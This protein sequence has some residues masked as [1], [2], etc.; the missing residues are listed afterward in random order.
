MIII[1]E[2]LDRVGKDTQ[3]KLLQTKLID[4]PCHIFHYSA[5][6]NIDNKVCKKYSK[7]LYDDG[8]KII[9]KLYKNRH[10]IFNR[11]LLGE[12]VYSPLYRNYKGDY[13]Y[14]LEQKYKTKDFFKEIYLITFIDTVDNLIQRE[15]G[16][17]HSLDVN[18]KQDEINKFIEAYNNSNIINKLL[19]N[20]NTKSI[21]IVHK[22]ICNFLNL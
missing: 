13:I 10:L 7:K 3:I 22:E 9:G 16:L 2:G 18:H 8:F 17:S 11:F 5:I 14:K 4:K 21:D 20:I 6:K 12:I 19:I 1:C 15:D